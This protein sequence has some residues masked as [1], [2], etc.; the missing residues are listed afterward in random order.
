M[1]MVVTGNMM[2]A[3]IFLLPSSLAGL[4][5]ISLL[6]WLITVVGAFLLSLIFVRLGSSCQQ[7]IGIHAFISEGMG[8]R[9]GLVVIYGYWVSI[10]V[11]NI[12]V[13]ISGVS[14]LSNFVPSLSDPWLASLT[15]LVVIWFLSLLNMWDIRRIGQFQVVTTCCMLVPVILTCLLGWGSFQFENLLNSVNVTGKPTGF[16]LSESI[17]LT[18]WSFIGLES[19][20]NLSSH[21]KNPSR[22]VP[23]ATLLGTLIAGACY[24]VST[25]TIMGVIPNDVL[26]YSAA[27][28]SDAVSLLLG[29][30]GGTLV[31]VLAVIACLGS[32][33]GWILMH[34]QIAC[35]A[36]RNG[37]MP[38]VFGRLNRFNSPWLGLLIT[39]VL[40]SF[41][42]LLSVEPTVQEHYRVV[43]LTA[44]NIMLVI[45]LLAGISCWRIL[46]RSHQGLSTTW[47]I[48]ILSALAYCFWG[49]L[50]SE[51][52]IQT[53]LYALLF[54]SAQASP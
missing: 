6:G 11:G 38:A 21:A 45:Y 23:Y 29:Q 36:S 24:L 4:G 32:L 35:A 37:I 26:Q 44:V 48:V 5:S 17:T 54:N 50:S 25:T 42:I 47:G 3:G 31:G 20:C 28:F 49:L 30:W 19:A 2:G 22:D 13:A 41:M 12:A 9:I 46:R 34:S 16:A 39:A 27:P 7:G 10:W 43:T 33:N 52:G 1:T 8:L 53:Y 51:S 40:M 18:L 14:Y 15:G